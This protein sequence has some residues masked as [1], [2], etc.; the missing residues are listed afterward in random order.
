MWNS[1]VTMKLAIVLSFKPPGLPSK[2]IQCEP[3]DLI[4]HLWKSLVWGLDTLKG[5]SGSVQCH[6]CLL[7]WTSVFK[8]HRERK[9]GRWTWYY[10]LIGQAGWTN[11]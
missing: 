9:R 4:T 2:Y 8:L 6:L 1:D 11:R 7:Q 10:F 5:A 3:V